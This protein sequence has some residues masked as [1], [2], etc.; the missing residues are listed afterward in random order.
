MASFFATMPNISHTMKYKNP[1][2]GKDFEMQLEG[3]KDFFQLPSTTT[4]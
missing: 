2:S 1:K 3:I 4:A